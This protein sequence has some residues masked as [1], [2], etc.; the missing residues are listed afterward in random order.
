MQ[1]M[2]RVLVG[3]E[4]LWCNSN[5]GPMEFTVPS[6]TTVNS[7]MLYIKKESMILSNTLIFLI[8]SLL[9]LL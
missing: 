6:L 7:A 3:V 2:S 5:H 9:C 1:A 4:M 8:L